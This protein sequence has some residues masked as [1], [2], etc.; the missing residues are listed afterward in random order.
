MLY[1]FADMPWRKVVHFNILYLIALIEHQ[2]TAWTKISWL[3][4]LGCY[5][6]VELMQVFLYIMTIY[7]DPA[8]NV[9]YA[10]TST[11]F[12]VNYQITL[13]TSTFMAVFYVL[14]QFI[15]WTM[16]SVTVGQYEFT[17]FFPYMPMFLITILTAFVNN[18]RKTLAKERSEFSESLVDQ[19]RR[20]H[21]IMQAIP[22]GLLVVTEAQEIKT[23]NAELVRLLETES[24]EESIVEGLKKLRYEANK[25]YKS[26]IQEL[27]PDIFHFLAAK[28]P[29]QTLGLTLIN[30]HYLEWKASCGH[31]GPSKACVLT[32]RDFTDWVRLQAKLQMESSSK[33]ALLRSVSHELRT[34]TNAI[35]NLVREV[36]ETETLT[37][38][39]TEDL[40]LVNIC[41][42]FLLSMINDLLDFSK[43]I[44]GQFTLVKTVF[45]LAQELRYS[46]MLFEPQCRVK[47]LD[48]NINIDPLLPVQAYS[49]PNRIRQVLL[50]LLSN[51]VK[52]TKQGFIRVLALAVSPYRMRISVSDSGIGIPKA[53]QGNLFKLFG[54][55]EG[56]E[57][58][59]PQGCGLGLSIANAMAHELGG[60]EI[61]LESDEGKG[62]TFSFYVFLTEVL[63]KDMEETACSDILYEEIPL[64]V[65]EFLCLPK[66]QTGEHSFDRVRS[67]PSILIVDDS[68]FN[69]LVMRKLLTQLSLDCAEACSGLQALTT[70]KKIY[71]ER[72]HCFRLILMDLEMPEMGGLAATKEIFGMVSRN[73]L[74]RK[75]CIIACSAYSSSEDKALCSEAGMSAYLE[76]P[77][78]KERLEEV[79]TTFL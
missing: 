32:V 75:P 54:Q 17:T 41:T 44:A 21:S 34:P 30:G 24:T 6:Y 18:Y 13:N 26:E 31:W 37:T 22:D 16:I 27:W 61:E 38:R 3:K 66:L 77:V 79:L 64:E 56:N 65:N 51:S 5:V 15:S 1:S 70:I 29:P 55:I 10:M 19:E 43:L 47:Q 7:A 4:T 49:D 12:C 73:E 78:S 25:R 33:T 58:L 50:N 76:K 59:N 14:K 53:K 69:R 62:A 23:W 72:G 28:E 42:H 2:L 20:L 74:P 52:F 9:F 8:H 36:R 35:L 57:L 46:V 48:F 68:E 63:N 60:D 39:G 45:N 40:K 71:E 67:P 11:L